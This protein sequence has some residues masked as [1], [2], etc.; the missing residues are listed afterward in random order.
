MGH[1]VLTLIIYFKKISLGMPR[2]FFSNLANQVNHLRPI[3][4][5]HSEIM[6]KVVAALH[7]VLL[8]YVTSSSAVE[9][10]KGDDLA[11]ELLVNAECKE[12]DFFPIN[13]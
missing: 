9:R 4:G 11:K 10:V 1:I 12:K 3:L 6:K 7:M 8:I 5:N 2:I 13:S